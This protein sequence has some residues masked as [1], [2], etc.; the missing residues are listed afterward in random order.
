MF[1]Y[2]IFQP[3]K[4]VEIHRS[5]GIFRDEK[6]SDSLRMFADGIKEFQFSNCRDSVDNINGSYENVIEVNSVLKQERNK[7]HQSKANAVYP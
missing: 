6:A 4:S 3:D 2:L 5:M 1:A 7:K